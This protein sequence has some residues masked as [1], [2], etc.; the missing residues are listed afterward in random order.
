[1]PGAKCPLELKDK[2]PGVTWPAVEARPGGGEL[3]VLGGEEVGT[4]SPDASG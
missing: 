2:V 3:I 1:M 4:P